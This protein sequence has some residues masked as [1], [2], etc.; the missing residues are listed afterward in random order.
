M[1]FRAV[2]HRKINFFFFT[3]FKTKNK[4][5]LEEKVINCSY[6]FVNAS[7]YSYIPAIP[8]LRSVGRIWPGDILRAARGT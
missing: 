5:V 2:S 1:Q 7:T 6:R 8:N 3:T 4:N